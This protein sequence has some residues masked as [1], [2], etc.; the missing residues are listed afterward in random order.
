VVS[1]RVDQLKKLIQ[2]Y[3]HIPLTCLFFYLAW[4]FLF[5]PASE[6]P[7]YM[8]EWV[9]VVTTAFAAWVVSSMVSS[10]YNVAAVG[11]IAF[12]VYGLGVC[13][14][15]RTIA[16]LPCTTWEKTT[17]TA[18]IEE[19]V[20]QSGAHCVASEEYEC[21]VCTERTWRSYETHGN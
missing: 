20:T 3:A 12:W 6:D 15:N 8:V 17:C 21:D 14:R 16:Q 18:C 1:N 10:G 11:V 19:E 5:Y 7:V 4:K 9:I 2:N 13:V